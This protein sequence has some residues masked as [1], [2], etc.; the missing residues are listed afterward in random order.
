MPVD[1]SESE[2]DAQVEDPDEPHDLLQNPSQEAEANVADRA[3]DDDDSSASH[4]SSPALDYDAA[5][6]N[7]LQL[8][9]QARIEQETQDIEANWRRRLRTSTSAPSDAPILVIGAPLGK[10]LTAIEAASHLV[11]QWEAI[12]NQTLSATPEGAPSV[13]E[14]L[15]KARAQLA[16]LQSSVTDD[17]GTPLNSLQDHKQTTI[18]SRIQTLEAALEE[19]TFPPEHANISAAISL[20]RTSRIPYSS[21][22]AIIYAGHLVDFAPT[23]TSFPADRA[24][25]LDRYARMHG[26]GWPWFEAPPARAA[27]PL[28]S[29]SRGTWVPETD[30]TYDMGHY[31]VTM[32]FRRMRNLVYHPGPPSR[33]RRRSQSQDVRWP[34]A[35]SPVEE[36]ESPLDKTNPPPPRKPNPNPL[37]PST[38]RRSR[39]SRHPHMTPDPAEATLHFR[40]LLDTG[41]TLP[42]LHSRDAAALGIDRKSYAA[43]SC[44]SVETAG[45]DLLRTWLYEMQ[46]SVADT[47][48]C[49]PLV[50]STS[51]VWPAEEHALG[52]IVP[53]MVKPA[54]TGGSSSTKFSAPLGPQDACAVTIDGETTWLQSATAII[55]EAGGRDYGRLSGLLPVKCCY[56][57][58]TPSLGA[59]WLGEDRRDVLGAHRMPGQMR[60]APGSNR[61]CDP[62]QPRGLWEGVYGG[63]DGGRPAVLRMAHEGGEEGMLRMVDV[64]EKGWKGR[65][66]VMVVDGDGVRTKHVIEPRGLTSQRAKRVKLADE[67]DR[68]L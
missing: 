40:M 48:T 1:N 29:A 57:Q 22:W 51:P 9:E 39:P 19:S 68:G 26:E 4:D 42:M 5:K 8:I 31:S 50:S 60:W 7:E 56:V 24:D 38:L 44:I 43:V 55:D 12:Y 35:R 6:E 34:V 25:R 16:A 28:F 41:A 21:N 36:E 13:L 27:A 67:V 66:E 37:P 23:Y 58:A 53:V 10:N 54:S 62:G 63:E 49:E 52:G 46:V 15:T 18:A 11:T 3:Q 32:S 17:V 61:V 2:R 65:S 45:P 30:T 64:E 59:L 47:L 14:S 20:Y 33:K